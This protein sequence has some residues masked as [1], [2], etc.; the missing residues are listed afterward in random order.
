[1]LIVKE[2]LWQIAFAVMCILP[3]SCKP[4][5]NDPPT[6]VA[7]VFVIVPSHKAPFTA[8]LASVVRKQGMTPN[9]GKATDDK[10]YSTYVLEATSPSVYLR[11]ENVVLSGQEDP[12]SCGVYTEPHS[13]PGQY[14]VSVSPT[15]E[16][17]DP[18]ESR[19]L[20]VKIAKDLRE[21]GF[22]VRSTSLLCSSQ[23]KKI[24]R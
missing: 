7:E 5:S 23:S 18:E 14:F 12:Q 3:T 1:M 9:L 24:T 15:T 20:L 22:D 6:P 4:G 13:D 2:S 21:E 10:G 8:Y 17:A 16:T 11:S 19:T